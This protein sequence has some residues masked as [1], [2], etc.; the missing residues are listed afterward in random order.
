MVFDKYITLKERT[1]TVGQT[2]SGMWY[3]KEL[4]A[5]DTK[6]LDALIGEINKIFNKYN[7]QNKKE[8]ITTIKLKPKVKG[9]DTNAD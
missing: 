8:K 7:T 2:S 6:Q 5:E 9:L 1:I 4:P 3:C